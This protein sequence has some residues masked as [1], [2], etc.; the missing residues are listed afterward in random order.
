M[1]KFYAFRMQDRIGEFEVVK[2][3]KQL[4]QK[5][6]ANAWAVIRPGNGSDF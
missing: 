5:F 4:G 2:K 1:I 3:S 6:Y